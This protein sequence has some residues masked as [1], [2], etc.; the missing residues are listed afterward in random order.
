[1]PA[2]QF[3]TA[4]ANLAS[5]NAFLFL[6]THGPIFVA[7]SSSATLIQCGFQY[8]RWNC[9]PIPPLVVKTIG[10]KSIPRC[11]H[12]SLYFLVFVSSAALVPAFGLRKDSAHA[13]AP[14]WL[15]AVGFTM[16]TSMASRLSQE[17]LPQTCPSVCLLLPFA[18]VP[19]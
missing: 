2:L 6:A 17:R 18:E 4:T 3:A 14:E 9:S 16:L 19:T 1:M 7:S 15:G 11:S 8:R 10:T 5:Q 13:P 12:R